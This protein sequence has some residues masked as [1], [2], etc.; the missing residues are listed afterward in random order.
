[1]KIRRHYKKNTKS[2]YIYKIL[3]TL[4]KN[5]WIPCISFDIEEITQHGQN[6]A[7]GDQQD[8]DLIQSLI[9]MMILLK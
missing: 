2:L 8:C 3:E 7:F 1:M 9:S 6:D 5:I 4:S